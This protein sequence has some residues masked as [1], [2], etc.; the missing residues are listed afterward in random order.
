MLFYN[1]GGKHHARAAEHRALSDSRA[2]IARKPTIADI[3]QAR[4][5]RDNVLVDILG[6]G[7]TARALYA[8]V[9]RVVH[10]RNVIEL[11]EVVRVE[12]DKRL[13]TRVI[14]ANFLEQIFER[15]TRPVMLGVGV[16]TLVHYRARRARYFRG[17]VRAVVRH[18]EYIEQLAGVVRFEQTFYRVAYYLRFV[19]RRN[20]YAELMLDLGFL[21]GFGTHEKQQYVK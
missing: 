3:P 21:V 14:L 7:V 20:D 16:G 2:E 8:C 15:I 13:V 17:I 10:A 11:H 19:S 6:V 12:L 9:E 5:A 4:Y 1:L 18:D